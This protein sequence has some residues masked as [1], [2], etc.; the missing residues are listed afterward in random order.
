MVFHRRDKKYKENIAQL[1]RGGEFEMREKSYKNV[2]NS[3]PN[4]IRGGET[5]VMKKFINALLAFVLVFAMAVPALAAEDTAQANAATRLQ[6]LD[7]LQGYEDGSLGLDKD[8]TRA[9]FATVAVRLLGLESAAEVSKGATAFKDVAATHWAA[10]YINIAVQQGLLKG[11]PDGTFKPSQNVSGVE[12]LAILVRV[13]GYEPAVTGVWPSNYIVKAAQIGLSDGAKFDANAAAPRG[14][15]AQFADNALEVPKMVQT[16]YG[17]SLEYVVSG[18][19]TGVPEETLLDKDLGLDKVDAKVV[20]VDTDDKEISVKEKDSTGAYTTNETYTYLESLVVAGTENTI[21]T[22]WADD[23]V[24]VAL[25][26][27]STVVYDYIDEIDGADAGK[28]LNNIDDVKLLNSGSKYSL[29]SS[30]EF[31]IDGVDKNGTDILADN[32][33]AKFIL[34]DGKIETI[35]VFTL[36]NG[37]L[38]SDVTDAKLSYVQGAND[39]TIRDLDDAGKII[40][41][42][43]GALA[44]YDDLEEGMYF[45]YKEYNTADDEYIFVATDKSVSGKLDRVKSDELRIGGTYYDLATPSYI[46]TD[47]GDDYSTVTGVDDFDDFYGEDVAA[48]LN[49]KGEVVYVQS[50]VEETTSDFY[51]F[52]IS[53]TSFSKQLRIAKNVDGD[54]EEVI[55]LTDDLDWAGAVVGYDDDSDPLTPLVAYTTGYNVNGLYEFTVNED[56][57]V[58][59]IADPITSG[60]ITGD[61]FTDSYIAAGTD[62]HYVDSDTLVFNLVGG[63]E[64]LLWDDIK[65]TDLGANTVTFY[66]NDNPADV[67]VIT[68][69]VNVSF[70]SSDAGFGIVNADAEKISS[71]EYEVSV[72]LL[73]GTDTFTSEDNL[74]A[75]DEMDIIGFK[76][77]TEDEIDSVVE[78]TYNNLTAIAALNTDWTPVNDKTVVAG[79]IDGSYFKVDIAGTDTLYKLASN[80][81]VY[82]LNAD[83]DLVEADLSDVND[84]AGSEDNL[85]FLVEDGEVVLLFFY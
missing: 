80:A 83:G 39:K 5:K 29:A 65:D 85:T 37:G 15:V 28:V 16:G 43:N 81:L 51:G 59:A 45:D 41:V 48:S 44:T 11:Y 49:L 4:N 32:S 58:T 42:V 61:D 26:V 84:E 72:T 33:Y 73:D 62:R 2:N 36:A 3:Q 77:V 23:D 38:I 27:E 8:I 64:I 56:G 1:E 55:F 13:L 70:G 30:V 50:D 34:K 71:D 76:Y 31:F 67:I 25:E 79:S 24:V 53:S 35:E 69:A 68:A 63:E 9:E 60:S 66:E 18:T 46:S 54:L 12:A 17:D 75:V 14:L 21:V 52:L 7:I 10:G 20:S 22:L 19:V 74:S 82:E 47:N 57:E 40:V 78:A 6:N